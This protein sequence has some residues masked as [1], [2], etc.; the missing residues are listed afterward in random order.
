MVVLF[1]Q[2]GSSAYCLP[3]A[4][5]LSCFLVRKKG[6]ESFQLS[7][8]M[9]ENSFYWV[10]NIA[11]ELGKANAGLKYALSPQPSALVIG[12]YLSYRTYHSH[13]KRCAPLQWHTVIGQYPKASTLFGCLST[14]QWSTVPATWGSRGLGRSNNNARQGCGWSFGLANPARARCGRT[15]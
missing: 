8:I 7:V 12:S 10:F 6:P 5:F 4:G 1:R 11:K 13:S 9:C 15:R 14:K 2:T 3:L